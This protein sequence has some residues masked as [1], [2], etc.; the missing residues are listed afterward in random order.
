MRHRSQSARTN[1]KEL[2]GG[3]DRLI[4]CAAHRDGLEYFAGGTLVGRH[5]QFAKGLQRKRSTTS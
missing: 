5:P 1:G 4:A 2:V 3:G